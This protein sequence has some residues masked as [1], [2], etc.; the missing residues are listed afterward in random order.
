M[1]LF[2]TQTNDIDSWMGTMSFNGFS[3]RLR[4]KTSHA[5][6][7]ALMWITTSLLAD[8]VPLTLTLGPASGTTNTFEI[9]MDD[10]SV[11]I[12]NSL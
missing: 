2:L 3:W 8:V 9:I 12:H 10:V 11:F 5:I 4:M 7:G 6:V 1:A